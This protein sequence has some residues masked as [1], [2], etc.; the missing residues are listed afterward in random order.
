MSGTF[1]TGRT[2]KL[3]IESRI[4]A[5][6]RDWSIETTVEL[7]STNTIDSRFNSF[8]PG[9]AGATGSATVMYYRDTTNT[10]KQDFTHFISNIMTTSENGVTTSNLVD[11]ELR[12]DNTPTTGN[13]DII[14]CKGYITSMG[15]QVSTGEVTTIPISFTVSE[16]S[17]KLFTEVPS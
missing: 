13:T 12:V 14:K 9:V 4:M 15:I 17:G 2:G 6:I 8:V 10:D 16:T 5:K 1:Y 3:R 11:L 7:I